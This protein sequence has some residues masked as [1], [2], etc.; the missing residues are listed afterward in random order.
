VYA[1]HV[2]QNCGRPPSS[3]HDVCRAAVH[4]VNA[5]IVAAYDVDYTISALVK[6]TMIDNF[7]SFV[8]NQMPSSIVLLFKSLPSKENS[9]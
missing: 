5:K 3:L 6:N 9:A 8:K 7:C 4:V 2:L 1:L